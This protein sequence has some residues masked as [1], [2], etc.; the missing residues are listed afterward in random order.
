M[1]LLR[2]LFNSVLHQLLHVAFYSVHTATDVC[3]RLSGLWIFH[4]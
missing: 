2:N 4:Q 1:Q 3:D